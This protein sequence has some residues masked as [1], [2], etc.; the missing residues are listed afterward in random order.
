MINTPYCTTIPT[1]A[2]LENYVGKELGLS[3][4]V[5]ITQ[6]RIDQF[7]TATEDFQWIHT[8]PKRAAIESPYGTTIAHGFLVLS[9]ASSFAYAA[10]Q[11]GD[12]EMGVNYG[13]DK[14]RFPNATKVNS[15]IRGRVSLTSYEAIEK[16]AKFK[17]TIVFELRG[18]SKPAC[19]ADFLAIAYAK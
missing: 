9:L 12:F 16:G 4:W 7:A 2:E 15:Q 18:E 1:I 14:V 8:D 13:L 11:L 17:L 5:T 19:V 10:Y 3:D 6:E